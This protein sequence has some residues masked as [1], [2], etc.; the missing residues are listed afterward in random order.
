MV[1][2][3][4]L[5]ACEIVRHDVV[6]HITN[7][8]NCFLNKCQRLL[9]GQSTIDNPENLVRQ[10]TQ[11]EDEQNKNTTKTT[12]GKDEPNTF[13]TRNSERKDT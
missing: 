11:D 4:R 2:N 10:D 1:Y 8:I 9:K 13:F 6:L 12:E 7:L 5:N 3:C